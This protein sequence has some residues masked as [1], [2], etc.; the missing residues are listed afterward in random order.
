MAYQR[1]E[2][3][4]GRD[5][6]ARA[7][8]PRSLL[9]LE[10]REHIEV[11]PAIPLRRFLVHLCCRWFCNTRLLNSNSVAST[12]G[13]KCSRTCSLG[14]FLSSPYFHPY[15]S[16]HLFGKVILNEQIFGTCL[17]TRRSRMETTPQPGKSSLEWSPWTWARRTSRQ[18]SRS[19]SISKSPTEPRLTK[20]R[21]NKKLATM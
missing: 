19:F 6:E 10:K 13:E 18:F 4:G 21:W 20:R 17:L 14:M 5:K 7:L 15:L 8:L 1:F 16:S 11:T 2:Q 3:R 12:E 9:S